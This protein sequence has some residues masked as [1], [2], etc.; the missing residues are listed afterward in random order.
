[1][2]LRPW[3]E[4]IK[5]LRDIILKQDNLEETGLSISLMII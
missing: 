4:K 1:M 5:K 3:N 2:D